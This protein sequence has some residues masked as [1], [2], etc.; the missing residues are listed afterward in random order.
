MKK[1]LI[2]IVACLLIAGTL[3]AQTS[4]AGEGTYKNR[5]KEGDLTKNR[6]R[7]GDVFLE[8]PEARAAVLILTKE[9]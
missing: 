3:A 4:V 2:A 6:R 9:K 7:L 8:F 5:L 1:L